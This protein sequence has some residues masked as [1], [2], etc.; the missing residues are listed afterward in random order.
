MRIAV[1]I[2]TVLLLVVAPAMRPVAA[3]DASAVILEGFVRNEEGNPLVGAVISLFKENWTEKIVQSAKSRRDGSFLLE[4]LEPGRYVLN[5]AKTGYEPLTY[6]I[7]APLK[8]APLFVVLKGLGQGDKAGKDWG[9][10][11]VLRASTDRNVI[12]RNQEGGAAPSDGRRVLKEGAKPGPRGGQILFSTSQPLGGL[13]YNVWPSPLGTGFS[14][15]FA[16]VEPLSTNSNFVVTGLITSGTDSQYQIKNMINYQVTPGHKVQLSLRYDKAGAKERPIQDLDQV[17]SSTIE[18]AILKTIEPIQTINVGIQDY[19][20]IF[21]PLTVV[22]GFDIDYAKASRGMARINPRFQL[23]LNPAEDVSFRFMLNNDRVTHDNTLT[24][25]EGAPVTLASPTQ[26]GKFNNNTFVNHLDHMEAGFSYLLGDKTNLEISTFLDEIAGSGYPFVAILKSPDAIVAQT[27]LLPPDVTN[28]KGFRFN[29]RHE[30]SR[31]ITTSVLYVYGSGATM[32][33]PVTTLAESPTDWGS[34]MKSRYFNMVSASVDANIQ[35]TGT[36]IAAV[37]R[38]TDGTPLTPLD[39]H[40]DYYDVSDNSL[41][42]FIRQSIPILTS[43]GKWEAIIDIRNI[44][45]QGVL[46]Y[47]SPNGDLILVRATRSI[48][49]GISF[50]F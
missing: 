49:G 4:N 33:T 24:L 8:Q 13:G 25:P 17:N 5:V 39:I 41:N 22:Y 37:Y 29:V 38:R 1:S 18:S 46:A 10:D 47:E 43:L 28:S 15:R 36:N 31:A 21:E 34:A 35:K 3:A 23:Y 44:M 32:E 2:I 6:S 48:R 9:V 7:L 27:E 30:W 14:T 20:R 16:Y 19:F 50:R 45:N 40:S 12:F 42:F 11:T 26:I